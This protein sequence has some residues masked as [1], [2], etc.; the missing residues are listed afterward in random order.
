[1]QVTEALV[2][3]AKSIVLADC[4]HFPMYDRPEALAGLIREFAVSVKNNNAGA[5]R[6]DVVDP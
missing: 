5:S 4:G 1:M 2:R 3:G 6:I